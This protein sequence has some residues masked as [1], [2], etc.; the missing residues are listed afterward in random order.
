MSQRR[1]GSVALNPQGVG[2]PDAAH[3]GEEIDDRLGGER[4]N[5]RAANVFDRGESPR[6][7]IREA[8]PLDF[9]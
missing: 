1:S 7:E 3:S 4:W 2:F 6:Q 9:E 8:I 5:G